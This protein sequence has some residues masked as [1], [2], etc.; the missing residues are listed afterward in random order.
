MKNRIKAAW[1]C[2]LG[3]GVVCNCAFRFNADKLVVRT[4]GRKLRLLD[5]TFVAGWAALQN[6]EEADAAWV[7]IDYKYYWS[8]NYSDGKCIGAPEFSFS[9]GEG[10]DDEEMGR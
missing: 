2:L 3:N 4:K 10:L 8:K 9:V 1:N 6:Y 5:N 7:K